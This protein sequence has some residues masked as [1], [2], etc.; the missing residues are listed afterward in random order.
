VAAEELRRILARGARRRGWA[1]RRRP[2]ESLAAAAVLGIGAR[3][4]CSATAR[5][6]AWRAAAVLG[7]GARQRCSA[8]ARARAWR[9]AAVLGGWCSAAGA[10]RRARWRAAPATK[11]TSARPLQGCALPGAL[12]TLGGGGA[13]RE[14]REAAR[15]LLLAV[16]RSVSVSVLRQSFPAPSARAWPRYV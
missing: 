13:G 15:A 2:R 16:S 5:A 12:S 1:A 10:P 9:A 3:Q 8:T 6:R 4:R 7:V 14:E 11:G